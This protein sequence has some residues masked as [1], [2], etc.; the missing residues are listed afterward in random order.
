[1]TGGNCGKMGLNNMSSLLDNAKNQT[2]SSPVCL[3][4]QF[5]Q[6]VDYQNL[7]IFR[8]T[9]HKSFDV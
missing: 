8:N 7:K 1:M 2:N 5:L 4:Y 9:C 3:F 6:L